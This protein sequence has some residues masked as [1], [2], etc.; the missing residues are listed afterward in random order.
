MQNIQKWL[1]EHKNDKVRTQMYY[2]KQGIIT[3]HMAWASTE[4]RTRLAKEVYENIKAFINGE[5]RNIV[6]M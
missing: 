3:P 5:K 6:N 1:E 2:A 4:A